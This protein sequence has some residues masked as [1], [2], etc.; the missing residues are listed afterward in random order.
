MQVTVD[1][2]DLRRMF[3]D[4]RPVLKQALDGGLLGINV[5]GGFL[6]FTAKA[7]IIYER[8]FPC[9]VPGPAYATVLYKDI[10]DFLPN[11]GP[12]LID[13]EEKAVSIRTAQ[14]STTFKAAYGEVRPY[15]R[16][17]KDPK[18]VLS[19]T[20]LKLAQNFGELAPVSRGLK[21]ESSVVLKPPFAIC[22]YPTIWLEVPY[23]GFVTSISQ[24][25]LRTIAN[26][27]PKY[28]ALGEDA[29]EFQNGP[30]ILA[31]PRSPIG[32]VKNCSQILVDPSPAV[33][34]PDFNPQEQCASL[35]RA[36]KGPCKLTC[37]ADGWKVFYKNQEVEMAFSVGQ[38]TK[39]YYTLDTHVEY[40]TMLFRLLGVEAAGYFTK[41]SNAVMF[42]VPG[43][44]RLL[45]SII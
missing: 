6:I 4:L 33:P 42:E 38:C 9:N 16:R 26:F 25:E 14:F 34:L 3:A 1:S 36:A 13:I 7:G 30:A 32:D 5:E 41:A 29:V 15:V 24:K 12:A 43:V 2:K 18:P 20:Y 37:C 21:T 45:H 10:S 44:F 8:R 27:N 35:A 22:K 39:P 31:V 28:Y 19:G 23:A 40:L 17:C 11:T